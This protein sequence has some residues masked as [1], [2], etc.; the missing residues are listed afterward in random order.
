MAVGDELST[1]EEL[2][3]KVVEASVFSEFNELRLLAYTKAIGQR[4]VFNTTPEEYEEISAQVNKEL[5]EWSND[6]YERHEVSSLL[7]AAYMES[8]DE[9]EL[10]QILEFY[11][12][13]SG[14]KLLQILPMVIDLKSD[15]EKDFVEGFLNSRAESE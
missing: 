11:T 14:K 10:S 8:F 1:K 2:V 12:S 4:V 3:A 9:Q 6:F 7:Q 13:D 15:F 5:N